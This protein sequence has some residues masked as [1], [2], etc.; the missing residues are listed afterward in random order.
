MMDTITLRNT[1]QELRSS[2]QQIR[3][4]NETT[5]YPTA[6]LDASLLE[7]AAKDLEDAADEIER[8]RLPQSK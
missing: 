6:G 4:N 7:K 1:A 2:A 3:R 5:P 8:L